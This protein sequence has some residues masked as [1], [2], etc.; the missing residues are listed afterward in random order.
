MGFVLNETPG[1][2]I[3]QAT[4]DRVLVEAKRLGYRPHSAARALASGRSYIILLLLPDWPVEF[5]MRAHLD[6]AALVL[7]Q[8]GYS[9]VT[10]TPHPGGQ[11]VPLWESLAPDV[12]LALTSIP[13]EQ[14]AAIRGAGVTTL[15][16]GRDELS[17]GEEL[18]FADG[19]RLQIQHLVERG[20]T[21]IGFAGTADA[22]LADLTDER[23]RL[24]ESTHC[25]LTGRPLAAVARVDEENAAATVAAWVDDGIDGIAAYNDNVAALVVGAAVRQGLELPTRLAVVGHD[26]SP[27]AGLIVPSLSSIRIDSAGLGRFLAELALYRAAG[28][29]KPVAG[30]SPSATLVRRETS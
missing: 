24:A 27:L 1:Q 7:D 21:R 18:R 19:P 4:R 17:F 30:P 20:S 9:L 25:E 3:S 8:A 2:T 29:P 6:E 15:I 23:L 16:P 10:M 13:D 12:V 11:A 28:A 26:D 5:S 14:Y 22:R